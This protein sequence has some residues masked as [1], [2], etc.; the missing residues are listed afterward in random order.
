MKKGKKYNFLSART[1]KLLS[2]LDFDFASA[3]DPFTNTT[4]CGI[5]TH[6][7]EGVIEFMI[8]TDDYGKNL[9]IKYRQV[10]NDEKTGWFDISY[11]DFIGAMSNT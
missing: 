10:L 7:E 8:K 11:S 6:S 3:F 1:H 5:D 9:A 2:P 4:T